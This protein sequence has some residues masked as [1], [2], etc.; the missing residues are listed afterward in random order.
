MKQKFFSILVSLMLIPIFGMAEGLA[1][2]ASSVPLGDWDFCSPTHPCS[3]GQG[4]CDSDHDCQSGLK[5]MPNVGPSYGFAKG[6]DVCVGIADNATN[7]NNREL[8]GG[9]Q[10]SSSTN[11]SSSSGGLM[12]LLS[13][14]T[15]SSTSS[16]T[17]SQP[18][19]GGDNKNNLVKPGDP[20]W[21]VTKI[22]NGDGPCQ[23]G[24]GQCNNW[25][26]CAKGLT[27]K[28]YKCVKP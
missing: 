12:G 20:D 13:G 4:D 3:A 24:E 5:C 17:S 9:G 18:T 25:T 27:C 22:A 2:G 21:C 19:G 11:L 7:S 6:V 26:Q 14:L 10:E 23:E 1:Y 28:D 16:S 15:T 8:Y